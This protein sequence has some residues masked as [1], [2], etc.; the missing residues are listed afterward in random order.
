MIGTDE[1]WDEVSSIE[2]PP[3]VYFGKINF[4][5][6]ACV[7]VKGQGAVV[8]DPAQHKPEDRRI[9]IEI[10]IT[11]LSSARKQFVTERKALA[12][13]REWIKITLASIK[14]LG[15]KSAKEINS[16]WVQYVMEPTGR[17]YTD[18]NGIERDNTM[19]KILAVY[20]SEEAAE[21]AK[22]ELYGKA[23]SDEDLGLPLESDLP[24]NN[25]NGEREVAMKFLPS[26]VAMCNK[27]REK[28]AQMLA[29]QPLV[30]KYFTV[31]SP[32]VQILLA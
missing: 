21:A 10:S 28:I 1:L 9:Q 5:L 29:S 32:E 8:F 15:L 27:D 19:P 23:K 4:D 3:S 25:G 18:K 6:W 2:L 16:R 30:S 13:S 14:A 11:P 20:D 12:E 31:D 24:K 17:K 26:I 7:L 22:V